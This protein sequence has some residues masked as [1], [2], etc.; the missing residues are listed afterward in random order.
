M[1]GLVKSSMTNIMY[2]KLYKHSF[3]N[4]TKARRYID[5]YIKFIASRIELN[6]TRGEIEGHV[7]HIVP[8]SWGG[9][10]AKSNLVKLTYKEHIIAHHLLYYTEDPKMVMAFYSM[11][12][13]FHNNE[14]KYNLTAEQYQLL[15]EQARP[16]QGEIQKAK[17]ANPEIRKK[18]SNSLK[19]KCVGAN[20]SH[21]RAVINLVTMEVFPTAREAD[22]AYGYPIGTVSDGIINRYRVRGQQWE[23]QDVYV[24]GESKPI[25]PQQSSRFKG[26]KHSAETRKRISESLKG[27]SPLNNKKV[28]NLQTKEVFNSCSEACMRLGLNRTTMSS[29]IYHA[30]KR[31]SQVFSCGGYRWML[32]DDYVNGEQ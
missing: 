21:K 12:N 6:K 27:R 9:T 8:R 17:M 22:K 31:G 11:A 16:L 5:R 13:I 14:I 26:K 7:H 18:I 15:C 30:R 1:V 25:V 32:H 20:S 24:K 4:P 3:K 28:I 29:S 19:G 23:Y 10:N 2:D